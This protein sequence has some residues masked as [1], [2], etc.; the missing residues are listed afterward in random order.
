MKVSHLGTLILLLALLIPVTRALRPGG[1]PHVRVRV[2]DAYGNPVSAKKITL[3]ADGA[4]S[5]VPQEKP[6]STKYGRYILEVRVPGFSNATES[7]LIDQ[8]EQILAVA[9]KLGSMEAPAPR[10]SI[11]GHVVP[12]DAALRIRSTRLFG[13]YHADVP[14]APDGSFAFRNLECGDYMLIA[15]GGKECLGTRTARAT[16]IGAR[17]DIQLTSLS[18]GCVSVGQ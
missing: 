18:G 2:T 14:I 12:G 15:M 9:M 4:S 5:E 7:V 1:Q 11:V 8:P 16:V 3:T 6:F 13:S 17:A 10:C